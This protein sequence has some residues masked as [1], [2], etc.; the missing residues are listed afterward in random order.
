MWRACRST[1]RCLDAHVFL[2]PGVS[3]GT[4]RTVASQDAL[5]RTRSTYWLVAE[6]W[7][8]PRTHVEIFVAEA[9]AVR[10]LMLGDAVAPGVPHKAWSADAVARFL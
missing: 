6:Q 1:L 2:H 3:Y 4:R 9:L 8:L 10:A 5:L 7:T